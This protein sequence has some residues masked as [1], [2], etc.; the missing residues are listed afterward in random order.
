MALMGSALCFTICV[1]M[2]V[3]FYLKIFSKEGKEIGLWE[4]VVD[5]GLVVVCT[6]LG[7]VGTVFAVLPKEKIGIQ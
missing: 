5:Y 1:I 3:S 6:A 7:I 2:P 4:R